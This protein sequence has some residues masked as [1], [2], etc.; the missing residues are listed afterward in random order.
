MKTLLR[1][2]VIILACCSLAGSAV[3]QLKSTKHSIDFGSVRA[4]K[5]K[6]DS[7]YVRN[8]SSFAQTLTGA[9]AGNS[10]FTIS[11]WVQGRLCGPPSTV[12][13]RLP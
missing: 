5:N 2:V 10:R 9:T 12:T 6:V 11:A 3:A 4:L 1:F 13:S 7:L 8:D